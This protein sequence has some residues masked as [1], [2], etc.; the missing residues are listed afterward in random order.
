MNSEPEAPVKRDED[1][2]RQLDEDLRFLNWRL[3][4][5]EVLLRRVLEQVDTLDLSPLDTSG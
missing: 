1:L 4:K 3:S 2:I 5:I